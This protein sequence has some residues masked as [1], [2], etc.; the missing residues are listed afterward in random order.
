MDP[1]S[2]FKHAILDDFSI[3]SKANDMR[4]DALLVGQLDIGGFAANVIDEL[5]DVLP[6]EHPSYAELMRLLGDFLRELARKRRNKNR[7]RVCIG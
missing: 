3:A 6:V 7:K 2:A 5:L 1:P 4:T